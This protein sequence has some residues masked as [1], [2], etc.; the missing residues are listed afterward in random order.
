MAVTKIKPI[1]STVKKALDYIQNPDKTDGKLL[2]SSFGCSFE[3]ADIEFQMMLKQ[4]AMHKGNNLAHHLIQSFEPGEATPELAHEIGRQLADEVLG[5]KYEYVLSTHIDKGHIHNHILFCAVDMVEHKKYV[6]NKQSY[7]FIRRTSDRLCWENGLSVVKPGQSKG[8]S[9]A[10]YTAE[11]TGTSWKGK[12]KIT[13]DALIPLSKDFDD[14]LRRMEAA[15]YEIK[16]GKYISFRA[17]GQER[18]TRC[19]TLG[20]SYTEEAITDRIKG[21]PVARAPKPERKG[22]SLLIDIE[23]SIKTQQSAG[24][25]HWAKIENLKRAAKTVN[26]ITEHGIDAY[27]DL[28]SKIAKLAAAN[29]GVAAALK[30]AERRLADKALLMKHVTTYRQ[31]R[32]VADDY[33]RAKDKPRYRR[34]HESALILYEA[35]ARTL[36]EQGITKLPDLAALKTEYDRLA[37][38]KEKLA[39]EYGKAKRTMQEYGVIKKNVDGILRRAPE[40][41]RTQEL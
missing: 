14:F 34:E 10:E 39:A 11:K 4:A 24:Y 18:F 41:E 40:Q 12:L 3:T 35:A 23:N 22:V 33:K 8:K 16:R 27:G 30:G 28:E 31:T 26:F 9:Y 15:G 32:P 38:E 17:P 19:K 21:K 13:I 6:S 7:G 37:A 20:E 1:K 5:S 25:E 29:D 36:K 2:V